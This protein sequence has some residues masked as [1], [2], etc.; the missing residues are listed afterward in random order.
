MGVRYPQLR[1][2]QQCS[3]IS[4]DTAD[5][6]ETEGEGKRAFLIVT[7]Q[8][9]PNNDNVLKQDADVLKH[10]A[11]AQPP[12]CILAKNEQRCHGTV[13]DRLTLEKHCRKRYHRYLASTLCCVRQSRCVR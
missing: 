5:I 13:R 3:E 7:D 6:L 4:G 11:V 8:V 9:M 12:V 2:P 10:C 1:L